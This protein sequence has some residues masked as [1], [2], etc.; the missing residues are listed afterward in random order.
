MAL[1]KSQREITKDQYD[2][3]MQNRGYLTNA[4]KD[5]VFSVAELCGYGVYGAI[6]FEKDGKYYVGYSIGDSC[7]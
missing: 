4:D 2:R 3:A 7:D 6:V 5:D 1:I